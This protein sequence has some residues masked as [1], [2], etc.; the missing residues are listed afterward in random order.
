MGVRRVGA[1]PAATD[2]L[3][4]EDVFETENENEVPDRSSIVQ[5]GWDAVRRVQQEAREGFVTDFRFT[6][7][8]QL[9]KFMSAEPIAVFKQH[10]IQE[11]KGQGRMS[12]V[13]AGAKCPLCTKVGHKP[14]QKIAFSVVNFMVKPPKPQ[15]LVVGLKA[16]SAL[17]SHN[18]GRFGPLDK[19]YWALSKSG[20]GTK[21]TYA[22]I[23][24][25]ASMLAEDWDID[26]EEAAEALDSVEAVDK[27]A[28]REDSLDVLDEVASELS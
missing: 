14:Q 13:C 16:A 25:K 15:L 3:E 6:D 19:H 2:Y 8:M 4:D 12:Y 18:D 26:P 1:A 5:T 7:D 22:F 17:D 24:V 10:W 11:R 28:I 9:V 20:E 27:T 23:P 21:T